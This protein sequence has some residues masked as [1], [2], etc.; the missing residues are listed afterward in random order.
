VP[1]L[2]LKSEK[3]RVNLKSERRTPKKVKFLAKDE[4]AESTPDTQIRF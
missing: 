4:K 1:K 2:I 3:A